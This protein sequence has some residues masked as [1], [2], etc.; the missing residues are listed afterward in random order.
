MIELKVQHTF[1]SNQKRKYNFVMLR[2]GWI[3]TEGAGGKTRV[4]CWVPILYFIP[5]PDSSG[6]Q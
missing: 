4:R 5:I 1:E 3:K 2:E 6:G